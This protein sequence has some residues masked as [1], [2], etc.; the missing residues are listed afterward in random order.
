M[1]TIVDPRDGSLFAFMA[2]V[3]RATRSRELDRAVDCLRSI[4]EAL[5]LGR[6]SSPPQQVTSHSYNLF[7]ELP[8]T[9]LFGRSIR[10]DG[11][12]NRIPMTSAELLGSPWSLR[13][14]R[15]VAATSAV[16]PQPLV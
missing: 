12:G 15:R 9:Q 7:P 5:Y 3:P 11:C 10:E 14:I 13:H 1:E 16:S 4:R 8:F 6:S 2:L